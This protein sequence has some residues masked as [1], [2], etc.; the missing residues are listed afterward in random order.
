[1]R[2]ILKGN[3]VIS[4]LWSIYQTLL[5]HHRKKAV[6]MILLILAGGFLDVLGLA[7]ILPVSKLIFNP[8][9][10]HTNE[11]VK[12]VYD[13]L[14]FTSDT[15]FLM[16]VLVLLVLVFIVKNAGSLYI[17]N[18]QSKYSYAV[19]SDL[20]KRQ[21]NFILDHDLHY[22][23]T[24][25]SNLLVR[26]VQTIPFHFSTYLLLPMLVFLSELVVVAIIVVSI[27]LIN[28]TIISMVG[29]TLVPAFLIAYRFIK[30]RAH[31]FE[32]E[33]N[34]LSI[35]SNKYAYQT[36]FGYIDVKLFNKDNF[37]IRQF[38]KTQQ[39]FN[40]L[41]VSVFTLNLVPGKII[42]LTAILGIVFLFG[43]SVFNPLNR[44]EVSTL[45]PL[46][47]AAAY[48]MMPSMNR[49]LIALTSIK[50]FQYVFEILG[51]AKNASL[52]LAREE[53]KDKLKFNS[54]IKL[55]NVWYRYPGAPRSSL[56]DISF[57][58]KRG[59]KIG[60]IGKSGSGKT[61]FINVLLRFL[62]ETKGSIAL[63]GKVLTQADDVKWRNLI[64]YVKQNVFII[65]GNFYENIAFGV[66][67]ENVDE[68]KM[69]R[70]LRLS[71]LDEVIDN[72][73]E[74][75]DTNIGE[76]GTRLSGGQRQRIAI[77]R[78]LYKDAEILVFDEATSALD[79]QTEK[80]ITESI[81]SLSEANATMVIIA[82]RITT[83]KN[84]NRI[85]EMKDGQIIAE[86]NYKELA[87]TLVQ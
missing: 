12:P 68:E 35:A 37:F 87:Q 3:I 81:E 29:L 32:R 63:D 14:G 48:R 40:K 76:N 56:K 7:A 80:E 43:Y 51:E 39:R 26:H 24:H 41:N 9:V 57:E 25:N 85:F 84:C 61:T 21:F 5:P 52:E 18:Y 50:G 71:K 16:F 23:N 44:A 72:I 53:I 60:I 86:H 83:L 1:M 62:R 33:K 38:L 6:T 79:N 54:D 75:L 64:G 70:V 59:D 82:H 20:S 28:V 10:I 4:T 69:K 78:A 49:M 15:S 73:P 46:Y 65:D 36:I 27:S 13:A 30:T 74:G 47:L 11:Y 31:H 67:R 42:E 45:L 2:K 17:S 19:G 58:I 77:A 66:E 34:R 22:F 55:E 8:W